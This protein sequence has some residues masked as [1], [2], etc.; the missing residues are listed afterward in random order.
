MGT[1]S[2]ISAHELVQIMQQSFAASLRLYTR[3][4]VATMRR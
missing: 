2:G 3:A 4:V 1:N